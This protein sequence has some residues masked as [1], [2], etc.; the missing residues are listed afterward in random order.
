ME[1]RKTFRPRNHWSRLTIWT[2]NPVQLY[3]NFFVT[4]A[5]FAEAVGL[6]K[7]CRT[8][9]YWTYTI[10]T[11]IAICWTL[12]LVYYLELVATKWLN[13]DE[14]LN[15]FASV[16][17]VSKKKYWLTL[18]TIDTFANKVSFVEQLRVL[19]SVQREKPS[20]SSASLTES[21][22][23]TKFV[24]DIASNNLEPATEVKIVAAK[25]LPSSFI[26]SRYYAIVR[27]R[28]CK[29]MNQIMDNF[30]TEVEGDFDDTRSRS[31]F[32]CLD[33]ENESFNFLV[34]V[35]PKLV[36]I[37][38]KTIALAFKSKPMFPLFKKIPTRKKSYSLAWSESLTRDILSKIVE[39]SQKSEQEIT[40]TCITMALR[41][42]SQLMTGLIPDDVEA[43]LVDTAYPVGGRLLLPLESAHDAKTTLSKVKHRSLKAQ[44][45]RLTET[46]DWPE[47]NKVL[48]RVMKWL[49]PKLYFS[50]CPVIIHHVHSVHRDAIQ[51]GHLKSIY[52]WG[53]LLYDS[54]L[55]FGVSQSDSGI[56]IAIQSDKSVIQSATLLAE[57]IDKAINNICISYD[58]H[59]NRKS[60][61]PTPLIS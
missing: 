27:T 18:V 51:G 41:S 9:F 17:K 43:L 60:P 4:V 52:R 24:S 12:V 15:Q 5:T 56:Q 47:V 46:E 29:R 34:T 58:I 40:V 39:K 1:L 7:F 13:F 45:D 57:C 55:S 21:E 42:Y 22:K 26:S 53:P 59:W 11:A 16:L 36:R 25:S 3:W 37:V 48:P 49:L 33:I 14:L 35:L 20:L 10:L 30:I 2:L 61:P 6:A 50:H 38:H 32:E 54:V 23:L 19:F 44:L 31:V 8:L 28:D